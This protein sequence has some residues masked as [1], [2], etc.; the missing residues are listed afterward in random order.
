[1]NRCVLKA[2]DTI[3]NC[4]RPVISLGVSQHDM[5]K[6]KNLWKF[7]GLN[8]SSNLQ[9]NNERKKLN[10]YTNTF[11]MPNKR[12]QAFKLSEKLLLSQKT[13]ILQLLQLFAVI[14]NSVQGLQHCTSL[15]TTVFFFIFNRTLKVLSLFV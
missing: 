12:L 13:K 7:W 3:G 10:S 6:I 8:W 11:M 9:E 5:H 15:L 14:T 2:L 4:Q 1:M